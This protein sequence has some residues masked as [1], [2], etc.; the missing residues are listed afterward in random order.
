VP[1]MALDLGAME[2]RSRSAAQIEIGIGR[3]TALAG[4]LC[5]LVGTLAAIALAESSPW[6]IGAAI[7]IGLG[8]IIVATAVHQLIFDRDAGVLRIERSIAGLRSRTV[9]PLFHLRALVV[10]SRGVGSGY[11]AVIE[12]RIGEPILIDTRDRPGPLYDLVRAIADVTE[13]RLVYDATRAS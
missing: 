3:S 2:I 1:F 11:R 12:R 5:A 4:W 10:R 7:A 13:L 8:G 6:L 9:V